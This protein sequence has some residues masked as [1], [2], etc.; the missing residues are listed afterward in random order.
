MGLLPIGFYLVWLG[1]ERS[2]FGIAVMLVALI[3]AYIWFIWNFGSPTV[4]PAFI[5]SAASPKRFLAVNATITLFFTVLL[6]L[7]GA[8]LWPLL[9]PASIWL[10]ND[11]LELQMSPQTEFVWV[12]VCI[13][14]LFQLL[15][16][17]LWDYLRKYRWIRRLT[18][19]NV[20]W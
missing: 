15:Y 16:L 3:A 19:P 17:L 20:C 9:Y 14:M 8:V 6:L 10:G 1:L 18:I 2:D 4:T 13:N 7:L 11:L 5:K 12:Y